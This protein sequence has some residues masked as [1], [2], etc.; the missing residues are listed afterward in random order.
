MRRTGRTFNGCWKD[1]SRRAQT[2]SVCPGKNLEASSSRDAHFY[3][4]YRANRAPTLPQAQQEAVT[5]ASSSQTMVDTSGGV[6]DQTV[7]GDE[8]ATEPEEPEGEPSDNEQERIDIEVR[9]I[10]FR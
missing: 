6:G 5:L 7:K 1:V 8:E 4:T 3:G 2:C 10:L 9:D